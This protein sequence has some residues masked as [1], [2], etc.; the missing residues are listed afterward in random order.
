[1]LAGIA[2]IAMVDL[3]EVEPIAQ[4]VGQG[5]IR[6]RRAADDSPRRQGSPSGDDPFS[7]DLPL[8][9]RE[10]SE[11]EIALEY[12]ADGFG[13]VLVGDQLLVL[14][15][16]AQGNHA[17]DPK[18]SLFRCGDLVADALAGDL[19]LEL[20]EGQQHVE[21]QSPHAG[22]GVEG[23]GHRDEGDAV[24]IEQ[25]DELGEVGQRPG[26]A[27]DLVDH[28]DV[29]PALLDVGEQFLQRWPFHRAPGEPAIVIMISDHLP[30]LM[31]LAL[32]ICRRRLALSVE[33][34]E[35]LL[36]ALVRGD[37]GVDRAT[38]S[39]WRR[40]LHGA[41]SANEDGS[42][43]N[44]RAACL[45]AFPR[46]RPPAWRPFAPKK[47]RWPFHFVPVM[48]KATAGSCTW[49]LRS[50]ANPSSSAMPLWIRPCHS[51]V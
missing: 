23:L 9:R 11:R 43:A 3:A 24:L 30:S 41:A 13:L 42:R 49:F 18:A 25:L 2:F 26:Q 31:G 51:R 4:H 27:I 50:Q 28:D 15:L 46:S 12:H 32:H 40:R 5:A 21:G 45:A 36:E 16:I 29:D 34:V 6:Q 8:Q 33:G 1:M 17:A 38:L 35:L 10:R 47:N 7:P 39:F 20:G 44:L 22:R 48:A 37:T 14:D 19:A